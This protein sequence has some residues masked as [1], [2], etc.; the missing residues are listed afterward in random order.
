MTIAAPPVAPGNAPSNSFHKAPH[1]E[2]PR[3]EV[4][5]NILFRLMDPEPSLNLNPL[6]SVHDVNHHFSG[7]RSSAR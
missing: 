6:P 4:L 1:Q 2:D 5:K 7:V 3:P